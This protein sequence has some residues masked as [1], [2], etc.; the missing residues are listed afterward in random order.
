M[1]TL[2]G[3]LSLVRLALRLDRVRLPIWI[4]VTVGIALSTASTIPQLYPDEA[5]RQR[6]AGT[7]GSNPAMLAIYGPVYDTSVGAVVMWR[8]AIIGA[9]LAGLMS[10]LTI[11]R[12]T[13]QDEEA[14]RLELI[15]ATVVGRHAPMAAA[16]VVTIGA[17]LVMALLI[18]AGM[19]GQKL[20]VSGSF[21]A[22]FAIGGL[23]IVMAA[24]TAVAAQLSENART[25]TAIAGTAF[26][27]AF[28]LRLIGDA[29]GTDGPGWLT[30][31]SPVG[32]IEKV[33]AYA[34]D[35]WWVLS[36][37]A[38]FAIV[39][40]V[41]AYALVG[42]RDFGAGLVRPRPGPAGAG[43][44]L[45]GPFGLAWRLHRWAM[46]GW[47][48]GF[49][50]MGAA[51]G[52]IA[53]GAV[54]LL[55]DNPQIEKVLAQMGGSTA[56]VDAFM[57]AMMGL[58]ALVA[59]VYAVQATLRLRAEETTYRAEPVLATP[60]GRIRWATSH[61]VFATVGALLMLLVAGLA[62]GIAYGIQVDDVGGQ[63]GSVLKTAL[64]QLPATLVVAGIAM[65]LFGLA[66][67]YVIGGWAALTLFVL[68]GQLGPI[69]QLPQWAMDVSP[70][71]HV[72]K[73]TSAVTATPL[74]WLSVVAVVLGV[75]GL[76]GFRRRDVG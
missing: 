44:T 29:G 50:V 32:W 28:I 41:V 25:V 3:T 2:T 26:G 51:F 15:G 55:K 74:V 60:V 73:L 5:A 36:L 39:L 19:A 12:H 57:S 35:N 8:M 71:T 38:G 40:F 76:V 21:A 23:G 62:L 33:R 43:V 1:S 37:M 11:N 18:G 56:I 63:L 45:S 68:L 52:S 72:P 53:N 46:L 64:L 22:G 42:R 65:A 17:N 59:A 49:V 16:L 27:V 75:A 47:A 31:L 66:P 69:L 13:R 48:V 14:G 4:V 20:P 54:D 34:D 24:V 7:I 6:I 30:W 9:L 58:V 61:L 67:K 10:M 70:F